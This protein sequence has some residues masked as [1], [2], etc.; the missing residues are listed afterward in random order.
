[1]TPFEHNLQ[2]LLH[3]VYQPEVPDPAFVAEL[4]E[5]LRSTAQERAAVQASERRVGRGRGWLGWAMP[6]AAV[7]AV[8]GLIIY[9]RRPW[10]RR[11]APPLQRVDP[12]ALASWP[13]RLTPKAK[14]EAPKVQTLGVGESLR[15]ELGQRRRVK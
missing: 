8:V 9:A 10:P 15:T 13:Q 4:E 5:R 14:K 6:V 2:R 12:D 7:A 11:E 1:M 3:D